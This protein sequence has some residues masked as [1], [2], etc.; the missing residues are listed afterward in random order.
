MALGLVDRLRLIAV[1]TPIPGAVPQGVGFWR[2][3][4]PNSYTAT[5]MADLLKIADLGS[6]AFVVPTNRYPDATLNNYQTLLSP[7]PTTDSNTQ[8]EAQ[9]L[10]A[11]LNL[12]SGRLATTA[13]I[14]FSKVKNWNTIVTNTAGSSRITAL[15]LLRE[16]ERRL[17]NSPTCTQLETAKNLLEVLNMGKLTV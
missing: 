16:V 7:G 8:L 13:L 9:L 3:A 12:A 11:W 2:N 17:A 4:V 5:Q 15:N 10:G 6:R 1:I 14:D